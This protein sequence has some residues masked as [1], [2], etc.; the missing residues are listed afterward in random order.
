MVQVCICFL[1]LQ[2][3]FTSHMN[4]HNQTTDMFQLMLVSTFNQL[5]ASIHISIEVLP[6]Q[7]LVANLSMYNISPLYVQNTHSQ[8]ITK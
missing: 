6:V 5:K 2:L 8:T 4:L 7:Y 3:L 1:V